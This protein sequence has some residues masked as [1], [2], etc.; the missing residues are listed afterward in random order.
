MRRACGWQV[1]AGWAG[2]RELSCRCVRVGSRQESPIYSSDRW[3][4]SGCEWFSF[5][6]PIQLACR[7]TQQSGVACWCACV[8][9]PMPADGSE[10]R[11]SRVV[12]AVG[13]SAR[14]IYAQLAAADVALEP[15]PFAMGFRWGAD[16]RGGAPKR[17]CTTARLGR[18]E[19]PGSMIAKMDAALSR[20]CLAG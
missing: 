15:K 12:L 1:C 5:S 16:R 7:T 3:S 13:H 6:S 20:P 10:V 9:G 18:W 2:G 8:C 14:D 19:N 4:Y 11:A 17:V